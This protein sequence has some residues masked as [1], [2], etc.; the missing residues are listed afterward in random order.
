MIISIFASIWAQNLWD[1]LILKNEIKLLEQ[2][3]WKDTQF[4]V[5][6]YDHTNPFYE[7][8]NIIYKEYF[9]NWI[10]NSWNFFRNI[11]NFFTFIK[12]T[13]KSDLIIIWW[14]WIIYDNEKQTTKWPLN[15]WLYRVNIFNFLGKKYNFFAVWINIKNKIYYHELKKIFINANKITVRDNY[16][17]ELL[18]SLWINSIRVNDPVFYD[19]KEYNKNSFLIKKFNSLKFSSKDIQDLDLKWKKIAIAFRKWYLVEQDDKVSE[20]IEEWRINEII[21]LILEKWGEIILLPMSFHKTDIIANDYVFLSKFLRI[22]EK[23]RIISSMQEVYNKFIYKEFDICLAMRLHSVIL[24]QVYWI[25]FVWV[26]YSTKTDEI[27]K[28]IEKGK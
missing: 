11:C 18:K 7:K 20:K 15:A 2:E 12:V 3:Y 13:L 27:L 28:E 16:S 17:F 19:V 5:F 22:N 9:P 24:S 1:E 25:P 8:S 14:G 23:I 26:S 4:I 6:S 21:N 10:R